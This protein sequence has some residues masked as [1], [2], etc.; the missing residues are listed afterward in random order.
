MSKKYTSSKVHLVTREED[1]ELWICAFNN[2]DADDEHALKLAKGSWESYPM[3]ESYRPLPWRSVGSS[4]HVAHAPFLRVGEARREF[5][6]RLCRDPPRGILS[7]STL[8][9]LRCALT[10]YCEILV[11]TGKKLDDSPHWRAEHKEMIDRWHHEL[12]DLIDEIEAEY[13]FTFI[14]D[15]WGI[16]DQWGEFSEELEEWLDQEVGQRGEAWD[17]IDIS[18]NSV[19]AFKDLSAATLFKLKWN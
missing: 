14:V 2:Q 11:D 13:P 17:C 12:M 7:V 15:K 4:R 1:S 9:Q 18:R 3:E 5:D 10:Q 16:I 8:P 19:F 6:L